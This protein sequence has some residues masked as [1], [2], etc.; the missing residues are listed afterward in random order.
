[1]LFGHTTGNLN[2]RMPITYV[3]LQRMF[4]APDPISMWCVCEMPMMSSY[5]ERGEG[6]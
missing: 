5:T 1:M 6:M 4:I 3:W 2:R